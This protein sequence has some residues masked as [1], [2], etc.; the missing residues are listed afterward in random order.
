LLPDDLE[1]SL[2][3]RHEPFRVGAADDLPRPPTGI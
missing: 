3:G 2:G 1:V